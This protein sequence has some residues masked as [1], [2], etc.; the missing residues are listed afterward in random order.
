MHGGI[1][2]LRTAQF[3]AVRSFYLDRV[4]MTVW[5]EQP[6]IAILRHGNLL[7]GLHRR[8]EADL[9]GLLT[10]VYETRE[11]VDAM[12]ARLSD[13]ATTEL[14]ENPKYRIYNFF[15][16]DPEGRK[17]EFQS[18]QHPVPPVADD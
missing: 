15:G 1:V 12:Y 13:T 2:F 8:P 3:D 16:V 10:F 5:L 4:G 14:K 9:D 18:F 6:D 11:E 7:V 17:I